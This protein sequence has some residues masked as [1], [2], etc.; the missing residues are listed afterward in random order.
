MCSSYMVR[1]PWY[2]HCLLLYKYFKYTVAFLF[3]S[4]IHGRK[5]AV[6]ILPA[7]HQGNPFRTVPKDP[8][9]VRAE[10]AMKRATP[11]GPT[12]S[13][14][15]VP[16][17]AGTGGMPSAPIAGAAAGGAGRG[18]TPSRGRGG[19]QGAYGRGGYMGATA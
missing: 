16:M 3:I 1:L 10:A 4:E 15:T 17:A 8:K 11:Q 5:P 18:G 13:S 12:T 7:N 14:A 19:Y 6:K 9:E 2:I